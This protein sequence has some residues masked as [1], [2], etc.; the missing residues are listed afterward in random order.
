MANTKE[1]VNINKMYASESKISKDEFIQKYKITENGITNEEAE[2]KFRRLGPN[3]IRQAKPKKWYNY[4]LE[5]LVTPFNCILIGIALILIYTDVILAEAPSYANI[6]V[7]AILV[8]AS[9]LLDFF[10]EYRSNKAAEKLKK[11][12][13]T[14][15]TVIRNGKKIDIPIKDVVIGDTVVLSAGSMIPADLRVIEAKDLYVGQ[16]SLT[17]ESDSVKKTVELEDKEDEIDNISDFDN[18]CFMGTNVVSGSAKGVVIKTA[19]STYFGKIA[20]TITAGKAKTAFQKGIE[21]ISRLLIKFM[22]FMIPL[23]FVINVEKHEFVTAFTFAV[24]IAICITPLLLPVILSSSLSKGAIRMSKKKTIV[25]KLDS[26]Q[27]FGAM[28]ILCTDKTGTLTE[29]KIVLERYLDINGDED[30]RVL[31]H[32]FLNSY[33]QTGL[34]GS[35]DE[36]VIKRA[37]ENNLMELTEKYK[38]IDEI[39]FDFSRRRL[40]VIVSDGERRQ[41][42]TKGAVEEI[43]SICTMVDYK[44]QV[45]KITKEIKDNIKKISKQLNKEGLRV[46]AVC[47]KNDME[48]KSNFDLTSKSA[49]SSESDTFTSRSI[50]ALLAKNNVPSSHK[51]I[52]D[53]YLIIKKVFKFQACMSRISNVEKSLL[54]KYDFNILEFTTMKQMYNELGLLQKWS[55]SEDANLRDVADNILL[56]RVKELKFLEASRYASISN[57]IYNGYKALEQYLKE[58]SKFQ[59]VQTLRTL[60]F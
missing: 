50:A 3:E 44:G 34:K 29:D 38:I 22:L 11:M 54:E 12:V 9:T 26:I 53:N 5:S 14:K 4:F 49:F 51:R 27:N 60:N 6:I 33:F 48:N 42:I 2:E 18:I 20:H 36:A 21:N 39:P 41:L 10:E 55:L 56:I 45:S 7:I 58:I 13:A 59:T 23:V 35:I 17:G 40:S 32:A 28:N 46:V 30:I 52:A 37:S 57:E 47:Q 16:S 43:L 25:K 1:D 8:I 31:K 19:D 15:T 24:A